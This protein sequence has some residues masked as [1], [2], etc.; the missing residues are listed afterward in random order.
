MRRA[1]VAVV[2]VACIGGLGW[3]VSAR[4]RVEERAERIALRYDRSTDEVARLRADLH[5][6]EDEAEDERRSKRKWR[7]RHENLR[8]EL[9]SAR[10]DARRLRALAR[11][12][13]PADLPARTD[14]V[15]STDGSYL[16]AGSTGGPGHGT[17][18]IW[19]VTPSVT[20][21]SATMQWR[22]V[23]ETS[24]N[25]RSITIST[26]RGTEREPFDAWY[27]GISRMHDLTGDGLDDLLLFASSTGTAGCSVTR[28]LENGP[29]LAE[30]FR[31]ED[32]ESGIEARNGLLV[33]SDSLQPKGCKY[34][35]GCGSRTEW[36]RWDG[37]SWDVVRTRRTR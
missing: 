37:D 6:A 12:T 15:E 19:R 3:A 22:R 2:V 25:G 10:S 7:R 20:H 9:S 28:V 13:A 21:G 11:A 8:W 18:R 35:H 36:L 16:V 34:I 4:D 5:A 26:P 24:V 31:L 14:V 29:E 32:C 30:I 23:Y 1:L 33:Y 27:V 17:V